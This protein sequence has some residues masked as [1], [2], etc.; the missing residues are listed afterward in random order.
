MRKAPIS[1]TLYFSGLT[2]AIIALIYLLTELIEGPNIWALRTMVVLS[3]ANFT[4]LMVRFKKVSTTQEKTQ[5]ELQKL[6]HIS[7][8]IIYY[9]QH[10]HDIKNHLIVMYELANSGKVES[11]I[12][13]A[14][15]LIDKT[16]HAFVECQTGSN[17]LDVLLYSKIDIARETGID[18]QI[19]LDCTLQLSPKRTIDLISIFSNIID[20]AI[21]ATLAIEVA[22]ERTIQIS[23]TEDPIN[24]TIV[25]TNSFSPRKLIEPDRVF[26]KGYSTKMES[27][28]QGLGLSIVSRI[29]KSLEGDIHLEI[30]NGIFFQLKINLPKHNLS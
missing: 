10:R 27:G 12:D 21:E 1:M 15:N 5:L 4:F 11:L 23:L 19:D 2:I 14:K 26:E 29:V 24:A 17:E 18:I 7:D 9:R 30:F 25:I 28:N 22:S 3:I 16:T 6:S 20:N 8:E 13:Y